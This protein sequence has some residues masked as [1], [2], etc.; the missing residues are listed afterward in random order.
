[1]KT[2]SLHLLGR[3][4]PLACALALAGCTSVVKPPKTPYAGY[5]AREKISFKLAL[6]LTD[7]LRRTEWEQRTML[8]DRWIVPAGQAIAENAPGLARQTFT[9]VVDINNGSA[10]PH[11][12]D[13]TLT[14]KVVNIGFELGNT[15]FSRATVSLKV[16]WTLT[17]AAN[18]V[19]WSDTVAGTGIGSTGGSAPKDR[20][21]LALEEVLRKSQRQMWSAR[22]IR[23][24]AMKKY[25]GVK[26][27]DAPT[28]VG[29]PE[30]GE[31]CEALQ[32]SEPRDVIRALQGLRGLKAPEAVPEILPCLGH[33]SPN[34]VRDACRTL[35]VLGDKK[36][37]ASIEPLLKHDRS[38]V[39]KDAKN[40]IAILQAKP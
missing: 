21:K 13:G 2:K 20:F 32:S 35:A 19:I 39:R 6:N 18:Q 37:I 28:A 23:E 4:L 3:L 5:T 29:N 15:S 40:A 7:E 10:P 14:P 38:D 33:K 26:F 22:A 11:P 17:D 34:V 24:H 25:P 8:G 36:T 16:E 9:E 30:V 31:L 1:M 12:V 27:V